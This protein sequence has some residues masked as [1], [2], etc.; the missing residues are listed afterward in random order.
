MSSSVL[1]AYRAFMLT[2]DLVSTP[3][4]P[5]PA[6]VAHAPAPHTTM[7]DM[8]WAFGLASPGFGLFTRGV[9]RRLP[10]GRAADLGARVDAFFADR[11]AD[12][13]ASSTAPR[14]LVGALPFD[15][16]A[17]DVLFQPAVVDAKPW[18]TARTAP[19]SGDRRIT[20]EPARAAY[21]AAVARALDAIRASDDDAPLR[22]IVL[23]RS[24]RVSADEAIDPFGLWSNLG[25]DP[26]ATRFLTP[27]GAGPD[28]AMRRLVGASPELLVSR[29]GGTVLSHPLAGSA[30]R[31]VDIAQDRA[32]ADGL[33]AS[34]KD[35]REH[36]LVVE[37]ILDVLSPLCRDLIAPSGPSLVSTRSMWHL[38]TRIE[39]RL[40]NP[41][42]HSSA[43]L[44]ALLHPTPA[45]AGTPQGRA[46]DLIRDLEGYD[47][48]F[49]A[50]AV[51]WT[52]AVGDGDW[53]VSLRC[54]EIS[55]AQARLYAGAGVVEGSDPEA[56]AEETSGKLVAILQ[57]LGV[58]ETGRPLKAA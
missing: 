33:M 20:A 58:D 46:T 42:D 54:A 2:A 37:F 43:A 52:D 28:G 4:A 8:D 12:G 36:R 31:S 1:K 16:R 24:L 45:V 26:W 29:R 23:S 10:Q 14:L 51:G 40:R 17:P 35:Q 57:A 3:P 32:A 34:E 18:P 55:G 15:R 56:E 7:S 50:G 5:V 9:S 22:K 13:P 44:A 53:H 11:P 21:K 39:G 30:R 38:G 47:R 19:A 49:Y 27:L 41:E 25:A 6:D 48:G